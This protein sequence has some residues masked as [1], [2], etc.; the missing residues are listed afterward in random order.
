MR[1]TKQVLRKLC[2]VVI[3]SS[4]ILSTVSAVFADNFGIIS[5]ID[6]ENATKSG[7]NVTGTASV[8]GTSFTIVPANAGNDANIAKAEVASLE[9]Y[10]AY[11]PGVNDA[12]MGENAL[13]FSRSGQSNVL[14]RWNNMYDLSKTEVG[15]EYEVSLWVYTADIEEGGSKE[16]TSALRFFISKGGAYDSADP[17]TKNFSWNKE[18]PDQTWTKLSF[19]FEMTKAIQDAGANSFRLDSAGTAECSWAKTIFADNFTIAEVGTV[20]DSSDTVLPSEPSTSGIEE[21][22]DYDKIAGQSYETAVNV[23]YSLGVLT[24]NDDN[25]FEPDRELTRAELLTI[26]IRALGFSE[27]S[28]EPTFTDVSKTHWA[29]NTIGV[30]EAFGIVDGDGDGSFRPDSKVSVNETIK[31]IVA[32]V[33]YDVYAQSNGGYPNGYK[34]TASELDLYDDV[35]IKNEDAVLRWQCAQFL[36]NALEVKMLEKKYNID[37]NTVAVNSDGDTLLNKNLKSIKITGLLKAVPGGYID[38][39]L[40]VIDGYAQIDETKYRSNINLDSYLGKNCTFY[41]KKIDNEYVIVYCHEAKTVETMEISTDDIVSATADAGLNVTVSYRE[42]G[43]I[44]NTKA[45]TPDVLYNMQSVSYSTQ[46]ELQGILDNYINQGKIRIVDNN[47]VYSLFIED[48]KAYVVSRASEY[49]EKIYYI[50][51]GKGTDSTG[52]LDLA[53]KEFA[54]Y[55]PEG[56]KIGISD[57]K[58]NDVISVYSKLNGDCTIHVSREKTTGKIE[59]LKL[60][61]GEAPVDWQA[62]VTS[63]QYVEKVNKDYGG[64]NVLASD[65]SNLNLGENSSRFIALVNGASSAVPSG[66]QDPAFSASKIS[67]ADMAAAT[68]NADTSDDQLFN[69]IM[70]DESGNIKTTGNGIKQTAK[71]GVTMLRVNELFARI[72]PGNA[73]NPIKVKFKFDVYFTDI[74]KQQ[75]T[76]DTTGT[77]TQIPVT[78]SLRAGSSDVLSQTINVPVNKWTTIEPEW[79]LTGNASNI[80]GL[81]MNIGGGKGAATSYTKPFPATVYY[82]GNIKFLMEEEVIATPVTPPETCKYEVAVNGN[83]YRIADTFPNSILLWSPLGIGSKATFLLDHEGRIAGYISGKSQSG[84]YGIILNAFPEEGD[85][86]RGIVRMLTS[87]GKI[88]VLECADKISGFDGTG[89]V[90]KPLSYFITDS[91]SDPKTDWHIWSTNNSSNFQL[92]PRTWLT[93]ENK[94]RAASRKLVYYK[95]DSEGLITQILVPSMPIEMQQ[96]KIKMLRNFNCTSLTSSANAVVYRKGFDYLMVNNQNTPLEGESKSYKLSDDVLVFKIASNEY[97]EEDYSVVGLNNMADGAYPM[98]IYSFTDGETADAIVICPQNQSS[99]GFTNVM[100]ECFTYENDSWVI[101]GYSKG[102]KFSCKVPDNLRIMERLWYTDAGV[103]KLTRDNVE[104]AHENGVIPTCYTY[105]ALGRETPFVIDANLKE[106]DIVAIDI[107]N[108]AAT[109]VELV[110][111]I[112]D[113]IGATRNVHVQ[114]D[115]TSMLDQ[116]ITTKMGTV[117]EI[118]YASEYIQIDSY[119]WTSANFIVSGQSTSKVGGSSGAVGKAELWYKI[120]GLPVT[121]YEADGAFF[122]TGTI[123]DIEEDNE[124]IIIGRLSKPTAIFVWKR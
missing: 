56:K 55:N 101:N 20:T 30:G 96:S 12:R 92:T 79:T 95:T 109:A 7:A 34:A 41:L 3:S 59:T 118:D 46:S 104:A 24:G 26:I 62:P 57:L 22:R 120:A 107:K 70:K 80:H 91:P 124:I 64:W 28:D 108:G 85:Y 72:T 13:L 83:K 114:T 88:K 27:F 86:Q 53:N 113:G 66:Y 21:I 67:I 112:D 2:S 37:G 16:G 93:T 31:M 75:G 52:T 4:I 115:I 82:S 69:A 58:E 18:I 111:R 110:S 103:T 65:S 35:E 60:I 48:Y 71:A 17:S 6:F 102:E 25:E 50:V 122:R 117:K 116:G 100:F 9:K 77:V 76:Q 99:A 8:G 33:G 10:E 73:Q 90:K 94:S 78:V 44:K 123:D 5:Q 97:W 19:K 68:T 106:G 63:L 14:T 39:G 38:G 84:D 15:T 45:M 1:K 11:Y 89:I 23:L 54:I 51:F 32:A 43:K 49:S 36:F 105:E 74:Y 87:D 61:E 29:Y 47:N 119:V 98:Q 42:S 81:R 121:I 40:E